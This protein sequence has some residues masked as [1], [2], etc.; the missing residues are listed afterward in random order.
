MLHLLHPGEKHDPGSVGGATES[1]SMKVCGANSVLE[2]LKSGKVVKIYY[3]SENE[4]IR[5]ILDLAKKLRVPVYRTR[6]QEK[7]CAE[8]SPVRY[9]TLEKI[10]EKAL[11]E[12]GFILILDGVNDPRNLGACIRTAEFFGCSGVVIKKRRAA[13][14]TEAVVRSS[15]G[16]VFHVEIA[17]EENLPSAVKRLKSLGFFILGAEIDGKEIMGVSMKPPVA[18]A[19]GGEDKG[20]SQGVKRLC[21]EIVR[22]PGVGKVKSLN[23]SVAAAIVMYEIF[24]SSNLSNV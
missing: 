21:D 19:V 14:I 18:L 9:S 22:I 23:L 24:K 11:A 7:V 12:N 10:G 17:A 6:V 5:E 20:I 3:S 15:A 2:A 8:I 16:A 4:K 1:G 13:P